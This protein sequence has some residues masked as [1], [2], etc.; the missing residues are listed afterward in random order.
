MTTY[1]IYTGY[2]NAV[3]GIEA[4]GTGWEYVNAASAEE[5]ARAA[6]DS[7]LQAGDVIVATDDNG[8]SYYLTV[9]ED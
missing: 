7:R 8:D 3:G 2:Y 6:D 9:D 5:A 1:R 4:H